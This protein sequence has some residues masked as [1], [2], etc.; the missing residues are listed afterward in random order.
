MPSSRLFMFGPVRLERDATAAPGLESRKALA[1]LCYIVLRG[2][3]VARPHLVDMFWGDMA[4]ERG[5]HNLRRVLSN[6]GAALPGWLD[7]ER[8]TVGYSPGPAAWT[9]VAVVA[10]LRAEGTREALATAVELMR[11]DLLADL[12]LDACPEF[13]TWLVVEREHWRQ[14]C[15]EMLERLLAYCE[16]TGDYTDG[17]TYAERLVALDPWREEGHRALM[18]LLALNGER[19]LA[20]SAYETLRRILAE[21]LHVEPTGETRRL[22]DQIAS[23]EIGP[24]VSPAPSHNLPGPLTPFVGRDAEMIELLSLLDPSAPSR[25]VTIIGL[26]GMGKSRLALEVAHRLWR[27][28]AHGACLA[29]L[30]SAAGPAFI[31][32]AIAAALGVRFEGPTD[33]RDQLLAYLRDKEML[34]VLDGFERHVAA[35]EVI[36]E[37]LRQAPGVKALVTS[38]TA[39]RL[40]A[41]H[42]FDLEG[43]PFPSGDDDGRPDYAGVQLFVQGAQRAR[44]R[45]SV[46]PSTLPAIVQICRALQ[47]LPL[48]I[49]L[50]AALVETQSCQEIAAE[51]ARDLDALATT[52]HD[53]PP[54]HRSLRAVFEHSWR[55]L[56]DDEQAAL[57]ALAVFA[58]GFDRAAAATVA[59]APAKMLAGL[60]SKSLLA[61]RDDDGDV[62][63]RYDMHALV[64]QYALE[65][66][67]RGAD[68]DRLMARHLGYYVALAEES[69]TGL[70]G[71]NQ[72]AWWKRLELEHDNVRHALAWG[73]AH[74]AH[75]SLRLAGALWRFWFERCDYAEGKR[76]LTS[77]LGAAG[78]AGADARAKALFGASRLA[79]AQGHIEAARRLLE[80][81]L[82]LARQASDRRLAAFTASDLGWRRHEA[83]ERESAKALWA[84]G[85]Q[86][87]QQAGD[88]WLVAVV[89][90][91]LGEAALNDGE[92]ATAELLLER[93]VDLARSAGD[94]LL[95]AFHLALLA[96]ARAARG[97]AAAASACLRES[98]AIR[99]Q[100]GNKANIAAC[101]EG[102]AAVTAAV[103]PSAGPTWAVTLLGAAAALR[104]AVQTPIPPVEIT[105]YAA[106]VE[107]LRSQLSEAEFSAAW[108]AG[109][110]M[111][112]EQVIAWA[113]AE[114]TEESPERT[115]PTRTT[116]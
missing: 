101:L 65:K 57:G 98:L 89:T 104:D 93:S 46:S 10:E 11:G 106:T 39:L 13:E 48:G 67:G 70:I 17:I 107:S 97:D 60:V 96:R 55:L 54:A 62:P 68:Y 90:A 42:V 69:E 110:A 78:A 91:S 45:F 49:E 52:L 35:A 103:R 88:G 76:W 26:G 25:L 37:I 114:P 14:R 61:Q 29:P 27:S 84:E 112:L 79:H 16:Q 109:R 53:I 1:L 82:P 6:I 30:E 19:N 95:L 51:I 59:G 86:M 115:F 38:R 81:G 63:V 50:A 15:A 71:V 56:T 77:A 8:H 21:D 80:E 92:V 33:P 64:R 94:A 18:R 3:R 87:A 105:A 40:H 22:R 31:V 74:D 66:V 85:L 41:E 43:L 108:A 99:R 5:R 102:L 111:S 20:L 116:S 7:V 73:I 28:Y 83:G 100:Y 9:D 32:S 113:E 24:S 12:T 75:V 47:G 4:E 23:G 34:L 72:A 2:E 44:R 58:G 36:I